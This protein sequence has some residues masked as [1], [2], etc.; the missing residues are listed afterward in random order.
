MAALD[1]HIPELALD[2][3]ASIPERQWQS[4]DGT[5]CFADISGFTSLAERLSR[6]GR[7]GGEE[8]ITTL[9]RV[10]GPM[11]DCAREYDG[12][13]LKFGGDALLFLFTG[14]DHA[15]RA[16]SA[17]V[18]MR[19]ALRVAAERPT[20]VGRIR[21]S[22]SVGLH[23]GALDFFLVGGS[24]RELVLVGPQATAAADCEAAA[25]AGEIAVTESTAALLPGDA[26]RARED[27]LRL[28]R[29]RQP[30]TGPDGLSLI[31]I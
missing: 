7:V 17:A 20:S 30:A 26:I 2:W 22:M 24:H 31:H 27:G 19:S 28:L 9:N 12:M 18:G 11:L 10:F 21:L 13:L 16:A 3:A 1:R 14:P 25:N 4:V 5:L 6:Q 15:M 29:W 23:S 8:L